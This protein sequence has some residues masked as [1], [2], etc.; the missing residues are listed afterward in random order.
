M[1]VRP[2]LRVAGALMGIKYPISREELT[3]HVTQHGGQPQVL[4]ALQ[5]LPN[6]SFVD[7]Q[8]LATEL[9]VEK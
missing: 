8:D 4:A 7:E 2:P 9:R 1:S 5:A 3:S 6:R